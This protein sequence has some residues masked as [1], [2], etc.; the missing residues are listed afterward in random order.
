[1]FMLDTIRT[2]KEEEKSLQSYHQQEKKILILPKFSSVWN[3]DVG[4]A[5]KPCR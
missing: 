2:P 4:K 5:I 1:M 3:K